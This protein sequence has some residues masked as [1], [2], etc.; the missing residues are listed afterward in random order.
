MFF[1]PQPVIIP[2]GGFKLLQ[3]RR[4]VTTHDT[5]AAQIDRDTM[6]STAPVYGGD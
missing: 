1:S 6:S 3:A 4:R 2:Q 5:L